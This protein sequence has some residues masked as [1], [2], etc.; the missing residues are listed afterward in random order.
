M[1]KSWSLVL[2]VIGETS[3]FSVLNEVKNKEASYDAQAVILV[4]LEERTTL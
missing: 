1:E 2:V 3:G 4:R